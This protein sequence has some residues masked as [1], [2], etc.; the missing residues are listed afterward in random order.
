MTEENNLNIRKRAAGLAATVGLI[1]GLFAMG[2]PAAHAVTVGNCSGFTF[3]G[4]LTPPLAGNGDATATVAAL[5][6]AKAG[7]VS[8]GVGFAFTRTATAATCNVLTVSANDGKVGGKLS[9]VASCNSASTDPTQYPLNGKVKIGY[10]AGAHSEA[11]YI[12]VAGFDPVPG[13]DV[14]AITGIVTKGD[15]PGATVSGESAFDPV[16]LAAVNDDPVAIAQG[17]APGQVLKKQYFFDNSQV[18]LPCGSAPTAPSVGTIVGGDGVS[19]LGSVV[20]G[21]LNFDL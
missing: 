8:W 9:G 11:M 2:A 10:A 6:S 20:L 5:K 4:T 16:L 14:V 21:G 1:G 3:V 15:T 19:L 13:P 18:V 17:A 7:S 12:R